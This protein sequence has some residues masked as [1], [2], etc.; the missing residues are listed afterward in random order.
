MM[1]TIRSSSSEVSSPALFI[2]KFSKIIYSPLVKVH[3]GL[4]AH[5]VRIPPADTLYLGEGVH[6]LVLAID[7]GVEQTQDELEIA[8][9]ILNQSCS[10]SKKQSACVTYT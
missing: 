2:S 4:L 3:I 10:I 7:V 9:F 5:Q 1:V 6:D 8:L